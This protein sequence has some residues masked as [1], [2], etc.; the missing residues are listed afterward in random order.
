[1]RLYMVS[2]YD[3]RAQEFGPP[4]C[5]HTLGT[6]ERMFQDVV[7]DPQSPVSK[8]PEDYALFQIGEFESATGMSK[9]T[10]PNLL[11]NAIQLLQNKQ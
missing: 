1:M 6:A 9:A 10:E 4:M 7:N 8:H 2:I 5:Q 11:C 3:K